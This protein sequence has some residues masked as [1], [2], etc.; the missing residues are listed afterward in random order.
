M[1]IS[2]NFVHLKCRVLYF[3]Q[4]FRI[5]SIQEEKSKTERDTEIAV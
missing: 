1:Y 4:K 3:A 5:I 2:K